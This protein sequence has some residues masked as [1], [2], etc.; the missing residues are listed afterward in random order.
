MFNSMQP[1]FSGV[2]QYVGERKP[3]KYILHSLA[4]KKGIGGIQPADA[5]MRTTYEA[6]VKA[7]GHKINAPRDCVVGILLT[8][9]HADAYRSLTIFEK[10]K[11]DLDCEMPNDFFEYTKPH[12]PDAIMAI[13]KSKRDTL[14]IYGPWKKPYSSSQSGKN[15]TPSKI[16]IKEIEMGKNYRAFFSRDAERRKTIAETVDDFDGASTSGYKS[17]LPNMSDLNPFEDFYY[18]YLDH[19]ENKRKP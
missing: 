5:K 3:V 15:P 17:A 6:L 16:P 9:D 10:A 19:I 18:S 7:S 1:H 2:Y 12:N 8:D 14:E 4:S 13:R 11:G